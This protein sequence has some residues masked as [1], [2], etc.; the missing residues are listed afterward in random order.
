[1]TAIQLSH[2]ARLP[3]GAFQ[4]SFTNSQGPSFS[5]FGATNPSSPFNDWVMLGGATEISPGQF[6]FTDPQATNNAKRFYRI[7]SP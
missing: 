5:V 3:S 7:R 6:Q 4:F 2:A 1:M